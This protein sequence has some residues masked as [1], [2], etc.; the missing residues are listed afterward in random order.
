MVTIDCEPSQAR[1]GAAVAIDSGAV[2]R[3]PPLLCSLCGDVESP[4]AEAFYYGD[5]ESPWAEAFYYGVIG[6]SE[7]R[8]LYCGDVEPPW[9]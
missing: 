6:S 5:L 7:L 4:W 1:K 8:A 2:I 3:F 9:A